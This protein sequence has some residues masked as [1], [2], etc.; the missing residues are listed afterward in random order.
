MLRPLLAALVLLAL[1]A[2]AQNRAPLDPG[3]RPVTKAFAITDA[4]VVAAPGRVLDGATVVVRDGLIEAVGADVDVPFDAEV[5]EGDSLTVYAGFIDALSHTAIPE[6]D[7]EADEDEVRD[8]GNPP[9]DR[10]GLRPEREARDLL[11]IGAGSAETLR[12]LGFTVAHVVPRDGFLAG[13]GAVILLA[14][15]SPDALV[16]RRGASLFAQFDAADGVY[17]ATP[18]GVMAALRQHVRDAARLETAERLYEA[19]PARLER[20]LADPALTALAPAARGEQ[21]V[22]FAVDD[23]LE[24]HRA[25]AVADELGLDLVLGGV[26]ES[27]NLTD[28]L[29]AAAVPVLASLD[30][31]E[32][33]DDSTA[34][35]S[36]AVPVAAAGERVFITE[37]RTRSFADVDDEAEALRAKRREAIS[38]YERNAATLHAAGIPFAFTTRGAEPGDVRAD[39][40]RIVA[41]G[42][43]EDDALAALTTTPAALLGLERSLGTVEAGK[44]ANLVVTRGSYFDDDAPLRLVVVDGV[45][46]EMDEEENFDPDAEIEVAGT[47]AYRLVF[48]GG[49]ETG[50]LTITDDAG[51]LGG[52]ITVPGGGTRDLADVELDGNRLSF[53]VRDTPFGAVE[54][55]GLVTADA[56]EAEVSGPGAPPLTLNATRRP[57]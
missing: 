38:L 30:L 3:V 52:T 55:S 36:A 2:A 15:A 4:R 20:P 33:E 50:T 7:D 27:S 10:A 28:K 24:A 44:M 45:R 11:E 39:L 53:R 49:V 42:L 16:L 47:W 8:P 6:P 23:V 37:R 26:R 48:D 29:R 19:D 54:V 21:T 5:I 51:A 13:Q 31:P 34:A 32:A 41:A 56:Y 9:R 1:P 35:D 43:S 14:D 18:M 22:F 12:D 57:D 40:R 17:P 46:F 25:L